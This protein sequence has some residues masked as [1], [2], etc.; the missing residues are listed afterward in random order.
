MDYRRCL[1][2]WIKQKVGLETYNYK[3]TLKSLNQMLH[4]AKD[5]IKNKSVKMKYI[6]ENSKNTKVLKSK[7][8]KKLTEKA[9]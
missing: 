2:R 8:I 9:N 6:N 5:Y 4:W 7:D 3:P 1:T